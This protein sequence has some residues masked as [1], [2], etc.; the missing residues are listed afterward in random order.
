MNI[1]EAQRTSSSERQTGSQLSSS[2]S[3]SATANTVD[4]WLQIDLRGYKWI[5]GVSTKGRSDADEWVTKYQVKTSLD[6]SNWDDGMLFQGNSDRNT[7]KENIFP[8]AKVARYV[9]F[10]AKEW[11]GHISMRADVIVGDQNCLGDNYKS[12]LLLKIL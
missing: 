6:G 12:P 2:T 7:G 8:F 4:Q 5:R 11:S 3:W 9:R 10:L 1:P